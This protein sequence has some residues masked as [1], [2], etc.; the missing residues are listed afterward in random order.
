MQEPKIQAWPRSQA[1]E[2]HQ[3]SH[4]VDQDAKIEVTQ[5]DLDWQHNGELFRAQW[6]NATSGHQGRDATYRCDCDQW[7]DLTMDAIE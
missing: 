4:Q 3:N 6:A 1:T 2:E 7:M 5:V